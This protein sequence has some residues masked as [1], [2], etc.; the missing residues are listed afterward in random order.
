[1][2]EKEL[3]R[4]VEFKG[5][6]LQLDRVEVELPDGRASVREVVWH[7]GAVCAAV[8]TTDSEWVLVRQYRF[9]AQ[10]LLLEV[11]AGKIDAQEEPDVAIWRELREEIGLLSGKLERVCE[12]WST[13]GFCNERMT[14]YLVTQAVLGESALD[15]G[16]F[17]EVVRVSQSEGLAMAFDGRVR[18]AKSI[19]ALLAAGR[20]LGL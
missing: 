17:L 14:C 8:L 18:D 10:E 13:P 11:P 19:L 4:R 15:E 16:E 6:L 12:F 7:P 3:S 5:K 9:P 20:H 2:I 1:V